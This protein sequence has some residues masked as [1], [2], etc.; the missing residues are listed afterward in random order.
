[1]ITSSLTIALTIKADYP[2]KV[3]GF[4]F[5]KIVGLSCNGYLIRNLKP[6][7]HIFL[8][9]S[10]DLKDFICF[11]D[12]VM[13]LPRILHINHKKVSFFHAEISKSHFFNAKVQIIN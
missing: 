8:I 7:G 12:K 2:F 3:E 11:C 5:K 1:M 13:A 10:S 6:V 9:S 4:F